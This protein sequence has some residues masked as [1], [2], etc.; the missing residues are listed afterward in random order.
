MTHGMTDLEK[1]E[2]AARRAADNLRRA[3]SEQATAIAF[4]AY[5]LAKIIS[6][7]KKD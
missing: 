3:N 5:E 7:E 2:L 6:E 1:V 4:L